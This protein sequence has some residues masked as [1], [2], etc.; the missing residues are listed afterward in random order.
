M[1]RRDFLITGAALAF[2]GPA[3]AATGAR[4]KKGL[5]DQELAAGTTVFIDVYT[6]WCTT[7]R[8]QGSAIRKLRAENPAYDQHLTFIAVDWDKHASSQLAKRLRIPRRST[9]VVLKG[10]QEI[11]R[12]VASTGRKTIQE[13]MDAG[14]AAATA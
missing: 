10:D 5:V 2:A 4:Y 14:V 9:L 13:L 1:K 7:C 3:L 8:A 6:D 11:G 12:I